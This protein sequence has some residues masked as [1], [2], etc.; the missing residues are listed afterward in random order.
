MD[1]NKDKLL[2]FEEFSQFLDKIKRGGK[3]KY[4]D[5]QR[6]QMW[7]LLDKTQNGSITFSQFKS[8]FV[9]TDQHAPF[10][11]APKITEKILHQIQDNS[12]Q[13]KTLFQE[14]DEDQSGEIH[15]QE[16]VIVLSNINKIFK[17]TLS[18]EQI[19][20]LFEISDVEGC[21]YI[22]YESFLNSLMV[23]DAGALFEK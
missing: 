1:K 4:T 20:K 14:I 8:A 9:V 17:H 18:H 7:Q 2:D 23:E 21:G 6:Q 12:M 22:K 19:L 3:E 5:S 10:T 16:F 15:L 13:I 11:W